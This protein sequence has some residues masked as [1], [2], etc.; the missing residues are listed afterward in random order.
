MPILRPPDILDKIPQLFAQC[1]EYFIF[2]FNRLCANGSVK[3][4]PLVIYTN[5]LRTV[6]KGY[7][8]VPR[9]LRPQ[10]QSYG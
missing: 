5:V 3:T 6:K 4:E 9:P 2:V 10:S 1:R 7:E 8:L